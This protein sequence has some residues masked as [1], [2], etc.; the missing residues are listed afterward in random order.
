MPIQ[1][2]MTAARAP[3]VPASAEDP[4]YADAIGKNVI[5]PLVDK[6]IPVIADAYV[7]REFGT[8]AFSF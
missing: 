2:P 8:A 5:L 7:D 4:R 6:E 3:S 1:P